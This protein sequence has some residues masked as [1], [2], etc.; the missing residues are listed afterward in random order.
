[1]A[2]QNVL[3][4]E[5]WLPIYINH[6]FD[7]CMLRPISSN[8]SRKGFLIYIEYAGNIFDIILLPLI[9]QY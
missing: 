2:P 6:W 9:A 8:L 4:V 3:F 5:V 7:F 1:M